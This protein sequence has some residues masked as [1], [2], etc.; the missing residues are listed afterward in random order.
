MSKRMMFNV[1][2]LYTLIVTIIMCSRGDF[3]A[4]GVLFEN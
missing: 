4:L 2:L 1:P 3:R